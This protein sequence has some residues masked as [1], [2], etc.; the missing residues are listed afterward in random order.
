MRGFITRKKKAAA[1]GRLTSFRREPYRLRKIG[2][3]RL[4]RKSSPSH[5]GES[6][7]RPQ[8]AEGED[9]SQ[10]EE[11]GSRTYNSSKKETRVVILTTR[12]KG[13]LVRKFALLFPVGDLPGQE[14]F[15]TPPKRKG[16]TA[17]FPLAEEGELRPTHAGEKKASAENGSFS[18]E[19]REK[20]GN[21]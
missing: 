19:E 16:K 1:K 20:R 17:S 10:K 3:L 21:Y 11:R 4:A 14:A 8:P 12:R 7:Q 6:E 5:P 9:R 2:V 18:N 13:H 15:T